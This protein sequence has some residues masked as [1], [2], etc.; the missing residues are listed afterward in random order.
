MFGITTVTIGWAQPASTSKTFFKTEIKHEFSSVSSPDLFK[1]I[2]RGKNIFDAV[3]TFQILNANG[4]K[5]YDE[6]FT[7]GE[8]MEFGS[9]E[10]D[11]AYKRSK[12]DSVF[13]IGVLS[14]F[15]DERNFLRPAIKDSSEMKD[16]YSSFEDWNI[17]WQEKTPIGFSYQ[18]GAEDGRCIAYSLK[19]KKVILYFT[20]C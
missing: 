13:I 10:T 19:K 2:V 18:L 15:F 16:N 17:I 3:V 8:L 4:K 7:V 11:K 9:A 5:I 1:L 12:E 6:H 20:C 14:Q